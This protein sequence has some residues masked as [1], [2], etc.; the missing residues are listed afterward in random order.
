MTK[1]RIVWLNAVFLIATPLLAL[2]LV[3]WS[4]ATWVLGWQEVLLAVVLWWLT[5][6]GITAG[7]HRLFSHRSYKASTPVRW[8]WA[9]L[10]GAAWQ[11]S[12][13]TWCA[14]HRYHHRDV[15]TGG[16]PYSVRRGFLYAHMGW[17]MIEG[18][19]H[20]Q[21]DNVQD[22]WDDPVCRFQHKHYLALSTAFNVG[23]PLAVGLAVGR[24]WPM[25][26]FAGLLRVVLVHHFT[27][28]INSAAHTWGS[29]PWSTKDSSRDNWIL[30]LLTFGEGFHNY[31]HTFQ[32]DYRNGPRWYHWDPSKWT[33]WSLSKL[34]Q[35]AELRRMPDDVV[36]RRRFQHQRTQLLDAIGETFEDWR[37]RLLEQTHG[38]IAGRDA[39][40][41]AMSE[42]SEAL[43]DGM[44]QRV[45]DAEARME[46]ALS[47]LRD[48]RQRW[49]AAHSLRFELPVER[50]AQLEAELRELRRTFRTARSSVRAS[51]RHWEALCQ[52]YRVLYEAAPA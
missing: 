22:L 16:D 13:I 46:T 6:L 30:S 36:L 12:V 47:E 40:A 19:R 23:L 18:P 38:V 43:Q 34:G 51:I 37:E 25:L 3:P 10:G 2:L 17:V 48:A 26:I 24:V 27:F 1:P 33:I 4:I 32:T 35:A 49:A 8:L 11:N 29:Q 28:F 39:M 31:H 21:L 20:D 15:D 50:R 7:Y 42:R 9:V 5:G 14:G 45:L 44:R 41:Q 52:E